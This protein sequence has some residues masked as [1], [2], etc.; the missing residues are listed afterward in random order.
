M[1]LIDLDA[2]GKE[3]LLMG[4][5]AI[6]RG[7]LE[8]GVHVCT[9]YPG[10]PS[11]EIIETLA[12]VAK[13]RNL[14][15]EWSV[16][17]KV[18][19]EVAT[20]AAFSGLR[21]ISAMKQNGLNVA[22]DF[23]VPLS[24]MG[25]KGGLL[26]VTCDD[27][28]AHSSSTE[29]DTRLFAKIMDLPLLE[30]STFQ[31]AKEMTHWAFELSETIQ[32]VCMLRGVTR[33][34]HA[35]GNVKLGPLPRLGPQKAFFDK[36][37]PRLT[38]PVSPRHADLHKKLA[39]MDRFFSSSP[40]N[41][42]RG[43]QRPQVLIITCG[44]GWLYSQE[45]VQ[46][47]GLKDSVGILKIGT[48]WPLPA[49]L[50]GKHLAVSDRILFVEEVD[51]FLE[52]SV[53]E[54]AAEFAPKVGRKRFFGRKSE[55][56]PVFG[57]MTTDRVIEALKRILH[58][59][60]QS[61]PRK[62]EARAKEIS[63]EILPGRAMTFCPG[64]PHRAS[65]WSIKNVLQLDNRQGFVTGDI[66]CYALG[67]TSAGYAILKTHGAMGSGTGLAGGFGKLGRFGFDQSVISVCGDST[68]FHAAM[69]ALVNAHY[70][71]SNLVMVILDNS[72]TAMTGFQPHP[73]VGLNAMAEVTAPIDIE[74]VCRSF[75]AKV[76][77]GDPFDLTGTK[78]KLLQALEDPDGAKVLILRHKC[79]MIQVKEEKP[80]YR[81]QVNPELCIGED[82][83]CDRLCTRLFKCPGLIWDQK[84]S[85]AKIDEVLCVGC[86]VC[87]DICPEGAILKKE[88]S[89]HEA[90]ARAE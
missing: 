18:A 6:A 40:F 10:T 31:E 79:A 14:Y 59:K 61:R 43:P 24:M 82:C 54:L 1:A 47:T 16:N 84:T 41:R 22:S 21:A 38:T 60:Y 51:P 73:G 81:V 17:E 45:A 29:E 88:N 39:Q 11:T 44:S 89:L 75:G 66:G 3:L 83:G 46:L 52:G 12:A 33:I 67:R 7:A 27:P 42:Y 85:I 90:D 64:C 71:K 23:L 58:V 20:A 74:T 53:K 69:P 25:I 36:S 49:K 35:R 78:Q 8:A 28:S 19:L 37:R 68:F 70:N 13:S 34:S 48:T 76:D 63:E 55:H 86:G 26:V 62:Y 30:P 87:A 32:N 80:P 9:G 4:N 56:I 2:P 50:I 77:V 15:V 65:Y 57:E 72:A 5:E